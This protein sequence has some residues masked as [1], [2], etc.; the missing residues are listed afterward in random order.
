MHDVLIAGGGLAG[1]ACAAALSDAGVAVHLLERDARLGGRAASWTDDT[2]G[3]VIDIGPHVLHSEYRN[4][5]ALLDRLGTRDLITWQRA[6]LITL[7]TSSG[8]LVLRHRALPP[9][10]SLLPDFLRA[11]ELDWRDMLSNSRAT[12]HALRFHESALAALDRR[13]ALDFLRTQG[14]SERMIDWFWR[15]ATMAVMNVPLERCS[16]AAL[17]RVHRQLIGHRGIHFGFAG[18]GLAEL[19]ASQCVSVIEAAGGQVSLGTAVASLQFGAESHVA[20]LAGGERIETRYCVCALPPRELAVLHAAFAAFGA[21]ESS[22][23]ISVYL[24]FDRKLT[25]ECFWALL[26]S[27]R[28]LNYDFYDLSNI[29]PGWAGRPSLIASN[30]IYSHR[31]HPL[32]DEQ[33]VDATLCEIAEHVPAVAHARVRHASVHRIPMAIA[34]PTPGSEQIRPPARCAVPRLYLAGDWTKTGL[35]S[36]MESAVRSG[37]LAAEAVLEDLNKPRSVA[38]APRKPDG[39]AWLVNP[40]AA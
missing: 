40:A 11:P 32:S 23:Y 13:N 37:F 27:P 10:L 35:P 3:D 28:R 15:F 8:T 25:A 38:L 26:W 21:F 4:L 14:V 18:V 22:P 19:Y 29:R 34:C 12:W 9:P 2:T 17:M 36:S 39:L 30:I 16:A 33:I 1:L 5:P 20:L 7:S 6:K 24:W 31:A